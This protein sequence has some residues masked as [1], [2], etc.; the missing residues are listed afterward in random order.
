MAVSVYCQSEAS[1]KP[2][3]SLNPDLKNSWDPSE[4]LVHL[5]RLPDQRAAKMEEEK[6]C[7]FRPKSCL[8]PRTCCRWKG[9][10]DAFIPHLKEQ[11]KSIMML[12]G[13]DILFLAAD[14]DVPGAV[15]WVMLQSCFGFYFLLVLE[16]CEKHRGHQQFFA[17]VMLVGTRKQ[18]DNFT[19]RLELSGSCRRRLTWEAVP[20][21]ILEG[22]AS[23]VAN[24]DC[25]VFDKTTALLFADNGT[26]EI[27]VSIGCA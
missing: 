27:H 19:Y 24:R 5:H 22:V 1:V 3:S 4:L 11:H 25:L 7:Q 14:I 12:Q 18:A 15:N 13:R 21:S 2:V 26:L 23:V 10:L 16:K 20:H 8:C 6:L 9:S 17:A